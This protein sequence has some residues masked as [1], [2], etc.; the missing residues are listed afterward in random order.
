MTLISGWE[1]RLLNS[2]PVYKFIAVP[3]QR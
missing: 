2:I 3:I 1:M